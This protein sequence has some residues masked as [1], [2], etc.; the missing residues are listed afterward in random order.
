VTRWDD[1]FVFI[2]PEDD[3]RDVAERRAD[4]L[5]QGIDVEFIDQLSET[6][7]WQGAPDVT[8]ASLKKEKGSV[9]PNLNP[10]VRESP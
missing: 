8:T 5:A 2:K 7:C 9:F 4:L 1:E 3:Q 6:R 10:P